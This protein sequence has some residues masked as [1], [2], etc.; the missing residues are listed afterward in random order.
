M[1]C[2][3]YKYQGNNMQRTGIKPVTGL[4]LKPLGAH[5]GMLIPVSLQ[6]DK[7][8]IFPFAPLFHFSYG[9][10][11]ILYVFFKQTAMFFLF[12]CLKLCTVF[13]G[14][15]LKLL[16][17]FAK[18]FSI[19]RLRPERFLYKR[20]RFLLEN[21]KRRACRF[22]AIQQIRYQPWAFNYWKQ[23]EGVLSRLKGGYYIQ[24]TCCIL[25]EL[26]GGRKSKTWA[27][28]KRRTMQSTPEQ[29]Y[30]EKNSE[31]IK[32]KQKEE[33]KTKPQFIK[34]TNTNSTETS[35]LNLPTVLY[36]TL[37]PKRT[38]RSH[39]HI[40]RSYKKNP[41]LLSRPIVVLSKRGTCNTP[42]SYKIA[43]LHLMLC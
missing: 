34:Q 5:R 30:I 23:T 8:H 29:S 7:L 41:Y 9:I 22:Y 40:R 39:N 42:F 17:L 19:Q 11:H 10:L 37:Q 20:M 35:V 6:K 13:T 36:F 15:S 12:A 24:M 27:K 28:Q 31:K 38:S 21:L 33:K 25:N 43:I 26:N 32:A 18:V 2:K 3:L 16:T 14:F 1:D 4:V